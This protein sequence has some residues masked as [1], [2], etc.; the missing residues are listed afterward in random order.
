MAGMETM[1]A[2]SLHTVYLSLGSNLGNRRQNIRRAIV[3]IGDLI[4]SVDRQS[5][6]LETEPWGFSSD[7]KF[8]NAC[9]KVHTLLSPREVLQQAH[10]IEHRLGRVRKLPDEPSADDHDDSRNTISEDVHRAYADRPIDIDILLYDDLIVREPDL[11]IPHPLMLERDFVMIPL[12]EIV[13][14]EDV[15][16]IHPC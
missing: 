1:E 12:R 7:H 6:L 13:D 14:D 16:P 5:T 3:M 11:T 2:E 9:V 10:I 4:G 8:L 15:L